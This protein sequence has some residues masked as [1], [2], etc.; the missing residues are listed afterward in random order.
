MTAGFAHGHGNGHE[1]AH[2]QVSAQADCMVVSVAGEIDMRSSARL[3][4]ILEALAPASLCLVVDMTDMT[5]I[6][7]S[8]LGGL[9]AARNLARQHGTSVVLVHPPAQVRRLLTSNRLQSH[10]R[11]FD[12]VQDALAAA[13]PG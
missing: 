2:I 13:H 12:T 8:G 10:F 7:S 5:F 1:D 11:V 6:D 4:P 9:L 3:G